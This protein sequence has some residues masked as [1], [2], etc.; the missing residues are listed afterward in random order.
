MRPLLSCDIWWH[1]SALVYFQPRV[2]C[3][4]R[5]VIQHIDNGGHCDSNDCT[6]KLNKAP[7]YFSI[8]LIS[9]AISWQ[10]DV[11]IKRSTF[12]ICRIG[13]SLTFVGVFSR[14][15]D[16]RRELGEHV[17]ARCVGFAVFRSQ[18]RVAEVTWK[19][20]IPLSISLVCRGYCPLHP[21]APLGL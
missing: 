7:R 1:L 5:P 16:V 9:P 13:A 3:A 21:H 20:G 4:K 18:S 6:R 8:F 19:K 15:F 11:G 2:N 17:D 14:V 10:M 12:R